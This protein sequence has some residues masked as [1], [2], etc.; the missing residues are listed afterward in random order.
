VATNESEIVPCFV[1]DAV[2]EPCSEGDQDGRADGEGQESSQEPIAF[3][4]IDG[5][6]P[7]A[8]ARAAGVADERDGNQADLRRDETTTPI[9]RS[10][11]M[12]SNIPQ[13]NMQLEAATVAATDDGSARPIL[14]QST[15][16]VAADT[17]PDL[18]I[19]ASCSPEG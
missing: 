17:P 14:F 6:L 15:Q 8:S 5:T 2:A 7:N 19:D 16:S 9:E 18:D 1:D 12:S 4:D 10:R 13:V 3:P 11:E